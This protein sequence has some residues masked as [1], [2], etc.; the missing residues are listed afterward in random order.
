MREWGTEHVW[1]YNSCST[2]QRLGKEAHEKPD[3]TSDNRKEVPRLLFLLGKAGPP[4][5]CWSCACQ[6]I[7]RRQPALPCLG[8]PSRNSCLAMP[9]PGTRLHPLLFPLRQDTTEHQ[10]LPNSDPPQ[11]LY[12]QKF[13]LGDPGKS[14][15]CCFL[16]LSSTSS[17]LRGFGG[18]GRKEGK[19]IS[20]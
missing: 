14:E 12:R 6:R 2:S 17:K 7:C 1:S 10:G 16:G 4:S 20:I 8:D 3:F 5:V 15:I 13:A 9:R 19:C 11:G 18:R